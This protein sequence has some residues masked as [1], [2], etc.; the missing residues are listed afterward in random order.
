M[1]TTQVKIAAVLVLS[2]AIF[3]GGYK[4]AEWR[5]EADIAHIHTKL[6]EARAAAVEEGLA[7]HAAADALNAE[8]TKVREVVYRTIYKEV[9]NY[10]QN[11]D[12][13]RCV[14]L[15]DWVRIHN[16]A[17]AGASTGIADDNA[18]PAGND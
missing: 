1:I 14:L 15:D 7:R 12:A 6:A 5:Y 9:D 16:S 18:K 17:A 2:S 10:V 13:G 4:V 8:K 11:P 3:G